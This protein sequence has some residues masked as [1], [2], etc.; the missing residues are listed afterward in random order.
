MVEGEGGTSW[1]IR[2][3]TYTQPCVKQLASGNAL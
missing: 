1:E 3:D 2:I